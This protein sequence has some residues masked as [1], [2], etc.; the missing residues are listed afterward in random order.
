[1]ILNDGAWSL[2]IDSSYLLKQIKHSVLLQM[3]NCAFVEY[4]QRAVDST[5]LGL[6]ATSIHGTPEYLNGPSLSASV[7]EV[8]YSESIK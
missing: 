2:I 8:N 5:C 4:H 7:R 6:N 1:M 3:V